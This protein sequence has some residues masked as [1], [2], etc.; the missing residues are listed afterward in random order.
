MYR[1]S[2][3]TGLWTKKYVGHIV[4]GLRKNNA[5]PEYV[6][7]VITVAITTNKD[8]KERADEETRGITRIPGFVV[9]CSLG[10]FA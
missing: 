1:I 7:H 6:E 9:L 5:P 8:A 4:S 2:E 10:D 3:T